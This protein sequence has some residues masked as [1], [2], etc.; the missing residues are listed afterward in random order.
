MMGWP[1][2]NVN[3]QGATN[4]RNSMLTCVSW[5]I[6]GGMGLI[7]PRIAIRNNSDIIWFD[8]WDDY[9]FFFDENSLRT[10]LADECPQLKI[11][12]TYHPVSLQVNSTAG[13][14]THYIVGTLRKHVHDLLTSNAN[15]SEGISTV[16]WE[17]EPLFGWLFDRDGKSIHK[18]LSKAVKFRSDILLMASVVISL[19]PTNFIGV[20][21][22]CEADTG[23]YNYST[24]VTP[25]LETIKTSFS[26]INTIY[27]AV[28]TPE[29]ED[30]FRADMATHNL[31]IISK[32]SLL[33]S[34]KTSQ[35]LKE[36]HKLE[37]DQLGVIDYQVLKQSDYFFG[38]G[39]S[40]F[41]FGVAYERGYSNYNDCNCSLH[42]GVLYEFKCCF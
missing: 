11:F 3:P 19:L 36:M 10:V 39:I 5:A 23:A 15:Y 18:S 37:F 20:H 8:H 30:K 21:L 35:V 13:S 22:R 29:I 9:N 40:S 26:H 7:M 14:F 28:G 27:V 42:G 16:I 38:V 1:K 25:V 41:A 31:S 32:S 2:F 24:Q 33:S 34:N 12:D 17:N 4:L 6:D